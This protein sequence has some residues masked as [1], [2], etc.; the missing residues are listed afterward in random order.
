MHKNI[1]FISK[2]DTKL[3][4]GVI[5]LPLYF[6]AAAVTSLRWPIKKAQ[7]APRGAR[8]SPLFRCLRLISLH[9]A[10]STAAVVMEIDLGPASSLGT[11]AMGT[12]VRNALS[13]VEEDEGEEL[14]RHRSKHHGNFSMLIVIGDIGTDHQL[15]V[16]KQH[17]ERGE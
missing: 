13:A 1:Y 6:G 12:R 8:A 2:N 11:V 4:L 16:A 5:E 10:L 14:H 3:Y 17:I 9:S 7:T 15:Q